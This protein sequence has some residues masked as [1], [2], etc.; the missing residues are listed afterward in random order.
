M[1]ALNLSLVPSL[2][3]LLLSP[4]PPLA[5]FSIRPKRRG[6]R[7]ARTLRLAVGLGVNAAGLVLVWQAWVPGGVVA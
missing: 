7:V 1:S 5:T 3:T 4:S 6:W 2:P